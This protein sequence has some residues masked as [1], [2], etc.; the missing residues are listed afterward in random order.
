MLSFQNLISSLLESQPK[1]NKQDSLGRTAN[2]M[3]MG[4]MLM[5]TLLH[6][7]NI[8]HWFA[9][10]SVENKAMASNEIHVSVFWSELLL[11]RKGRG[12]PA[13]HHFSYDNS[14]PPSRMTKMRKKYQQPT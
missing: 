13:F 14:Q 4:Q 5:K 1:L 6:N 2:Y 11:L 12:K 8:V 3:E 7:F 9:S 10:F